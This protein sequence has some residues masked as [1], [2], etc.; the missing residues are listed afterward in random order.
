MKSF[1]IILSVLFLTACIKVVR[2]DEFSSQDIR[3]IACSGEKH[4]VNGVL[5]APDMSK[6]SEGRKK[7]FFECIKK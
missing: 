1:I 7:A 5:V 3:I 6:W 2:H 4:V